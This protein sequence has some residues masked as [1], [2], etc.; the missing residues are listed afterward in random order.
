VLEPAAVRGGVEQQARGILEPWVA[1]EEEGENLTT[2]A[3]EV[4]EGLRV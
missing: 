4:W 2:E 3:A 1:W